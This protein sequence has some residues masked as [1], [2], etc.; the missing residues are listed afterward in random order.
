MRFVISVTAVGSKRLSIGTLLGNRETAG[1]DLRP[2]GIHQRRAGGERRG[3]LCVY[4]WTVFIA[5]LIL[6]MVNPVTGPEDLDL[7]P[8]DK[9]SEN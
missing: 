4:N 2:L 1:N 8:R 9:S 3:R 6:S 5:E 7:P